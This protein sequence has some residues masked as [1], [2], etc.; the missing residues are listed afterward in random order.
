MPVRIYD[1]AKKLGIENKDVLAKA[2]ELGIAQAKVPSSSLD[3]I[4]A[5]FLENELVKL[6][7]PPIG[8][9]AAPAPEAPPAAPAPVETHPS[10]TL[11]TEAPPPVEP[12]A[13]A[14][15]PP[16]PA[17]T[18]LPPPVSVV[19]PS[20][21]TVTA[22]VEGPPSPPSPVSQVSVPAPVVEIPL[23]SAP[24]APVAPP[25]PPAAPPPP[26]VPKIGEKVGWVQLPPKSISR[27]QPDRSAGRGPSSGTRTGWP[28]RGELRRGPGAPA[29][30]APLPGGQRP[31]QR[32]AQKSAAPAT[33]AAKPA[34]KFVPLATG[35]LITLKPPIIVRDLAEQLKRKPFQIIADLMEVG[36]FANVNQSIDED[37]AQ[38][39]CA[40]HG[41]RFEVEKRER[42]AGTHTP[43]RKVELDVEDKAEDM[44][45]RA[46]VVTIMGHVDHGK[47]TLLDV[48][49]KSNVAADEAGGI[50]QHIGAY[51]IS[52]PHPERQNELQQIT[53]L[54][55]PG[56][57]AFSAMRARGATVTDI[58]VLVVAANDGVM[59]QT[60]EALSHAQA[61]KAPVIVAVNKCDH[62]NANPL[63][64][65]RCA[66]GK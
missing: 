46:P 26:P 32:P 58:V 42:G 39:I 14:P 12:V 48:I 53:F 29:S 6:F 7:P 8:A 18:G 65:T 33:G 27:P 37:V 24:A 9:P 1:L 59:P 4:T 54:D 19:E 34:E 3:K 20:P 30:A 11:I 31:G 23:P 25:A 63:N 36:V 10:I 56:H 21:E 43:V 40:K 52:F 5:G 44:K 55:T 13:A 41:F 62:P 28:A 57:A 47:T 60:L 45:P 50:T 51:T 17:Q 2:R 66:L 38:R 64:A 35:Q 49:R 15:P 22:S 16:A 61:A